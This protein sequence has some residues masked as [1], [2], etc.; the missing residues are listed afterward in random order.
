MSSKRYDPSRLQ[1]VT[2]V[3]PEV[4]TLT[5]EDEAPAAPQPAPAPAAFSP[6][7]MAQIRD[8]M[9]EAF[10]QGAASVPRLPDDQVKAQERLK[11]QAEAATRPH[12]VQSGALRHMQS[13]RD[14]TVIMGRSKIKDGEQIFEDTPVEFVIEPDGKRI[15]GGPH[16]GKFL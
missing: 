14:G 10:A 6:E 12:P 16:D 4:Q 2:P 8:M 7:Q 1:Q 11:K 9:K 3:A 5:S 15:V 13:L